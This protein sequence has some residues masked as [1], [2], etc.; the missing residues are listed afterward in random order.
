MNVLEI[1]RE[2]FVSTLTMSRPQAGNALEASL[3]AALDATLTD[4]ATNGTR[5]LVLRGAGK[6]F[7]AGFDLSALAKENDASLA[8]RF[9]RIE[10]M[11]AKL[12]TL[13]CLTVAY[14]HGAAF[15]AGADL[16]AACDARI[17]GEAASFAFPGAGFGIVLGTRR[18]A[19]RVGE[20]RAM[21]LVA[22]GARLNADEAKAYGL[23]TAAGDDET[24]RE[25]IATLSREL[26]R[27]DD[28]TFASV[29]RAA[30]GYTDLDAA[31]DLNV[32]QASATRA[33]LHERISAHAA[34]SKKPQH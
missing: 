17:A 10:I 16:F 8:A 19:L 31:R 3:V 18:L 7:C 29:V 15:G 32:L 2:G 13:P 25:A 6:H 28:A 22:S 12:A 4:C 27:L 30:R 5:L 34:R 14:A 24:A 21:R 23:A 1:S 33:G 9:T 20:L 11:L 26:Q